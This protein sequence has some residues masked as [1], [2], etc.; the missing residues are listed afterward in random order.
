MLENHSKITTKRN[1]HGKRHRQIKTND[2][3]KKQI[4]IK[5]QDICVGEINLTF[6]GLVFVKRTESEK[7]THKFH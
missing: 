2:S 3:K 6:P 1:F 7:K 4:E 5:S